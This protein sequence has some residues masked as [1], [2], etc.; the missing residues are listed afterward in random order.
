MKARIYRPAKTAMQSGAGKTNEWKL[1]FLPQAAPF[2]DKTMGWTGMNDM[3]QEL[4]LSFATKEEAI[5]YA[6][7]N[8]IE[9]EVEEPKEKKFVPK[10][11]SANFAFD[12]IA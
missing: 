6:K 11:Y 12:R 7:N 10:S 1:D 3:L 2:I 9:F 5:A 8:A 4:N